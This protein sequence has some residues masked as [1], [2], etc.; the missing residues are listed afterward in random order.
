MYLITAST[1]STKSLYIGKLRAL[2]ALGKGKY[3]DVCLTDV[4][5]LNVS[6]VQTLF[7][8]AASGTENA[9]NDSAK[10]AAKGPQTGDTA[11]FMKRVYLEHVGYFMECEED[12]YEA[13][14][15]LTKSEKEDTE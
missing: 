5:V 7:G 13:F 2:E 12:V 14:V 10:R 8:P 4:V 11:M 6:A 1:T 15:Q 9:E 3:G